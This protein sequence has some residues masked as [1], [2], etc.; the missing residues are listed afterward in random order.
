MS[1]QPRKS[2]KPNTFYH[3][4]NRGNR[5][6]KILLETE[7]YERFV[8]LMQRFLT[9]NKYGLLIYCYCLMPNHYHLLIDSGSCP[10]EIT[11]FM[12]RFMTSYVMYFNKKYDYVGRLFQNSYRVK[13]IQDQN[14]FNKIVNYISQNPVKAGLV[15]NTE[16]YKWSKYNRL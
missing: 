4:Y 6:Q 10:M 12:H 2:Y 3:I 7:D 8:S 16:D 14:H 11:Y 5:K 9:T 13:T 1:F 15:Q